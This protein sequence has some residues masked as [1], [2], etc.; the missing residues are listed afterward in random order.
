MDDI[1]AQPSSLRVFDNVPVVDTAVS[2]EQKT[3]IVFGVPRGGTTMVARVVEKLGVVMGT[4]LPLNYEDNEF[5][6]DKMSDELKEDPEQ[7][8]RGL[9]R[10]INRRNSKFDVW[11]WK[12]PR[13][14][15]YLPKIIKHVRN[16]HLICVFRDPVA[17]ALRPLSRRQSPKNPSPLMPTKVVKQHLD[18]QTRNIQLIHKLSLPSFLCSYEKSIAD[19]SSFVGE[20]ASFIGAPVDAERLEAAVQQINPG[21]YMQ[22]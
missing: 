10:A 8:A 1:Q 19:P 4:K 18:W 11:G 14:H 15:L 13:A 6:Y 21:G 17:S 20:L 22:S 5:N 9:M 7:M 12:Y 3:F 16:P 2:P